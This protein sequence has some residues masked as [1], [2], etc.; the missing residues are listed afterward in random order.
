MFRLRVL[1]GFALE[2]PSGDTTPHLPQRRAEAVLAVLAVCGDLGCTRDRLIALLWPESD[3]AHARHSLRDALRAIRHVL[4]S[5]AI[6]S[7]GELLH[8]DPCVVGSDVLSFSLALSVDRHAHAVRAYSGALLEGFHVDGAPEFE[9]WLDGER[10]RLARQYAEALERLAKTAECDGEW[11]EAAGWW[12]RAVDHDPLNSHLVLHQVRALA[13]MGD[14][15]NAVQAADAHSRRLR[16]ELDLEPDREVLAKIERIRRGDLPTPPTPPRRRPPAPQ[17]SKP[18]EEAARH[19]EAPAASAA[20]P[21]ETAPERAVNQLPRWVRRT[22]V[23]AAAAI[24][25]LV[26]MQVFRRR[27]FTV[28]ASDMMQITSDPGV[29]FQPAI[30]PNGSEVAYVA[31][32]I[33]LPRPFVRSTAN[34][35]NGAAIR[36]DD[37]AMGSGWLPAWSPD[38]QLVR[39]LR[40]RAD[41]FSR[42][43][44]AETGKLGGLAR[45]VMRDTTIIAGMLESTVAWSPDGARVAFVVQDTIFT[46]SAGDTTRHPIAIHTAGHAEPHSLA[47]SPNG[48]YIA[49]VNSH[50]GWRIGLNRVAPASI[51]V[52]DASGGEPQ[53]VTDHDHLNVSPAWLDERHLLFVSNRD[54][55][56]ALYVVEVG[57]RGARGAPRLVPGVADPHSIS[58]SAASRRLAYSKFTV[59]QNIWAY[60]LDRSGPVSI[61]DGRPVTTGNQVVEWHDVSPDG[62]WIAYNGSRRGSGDLYRMPLAGGEAVPLTETPLQETQPRW[63][64]DGRE[65]VFYL[66]GPHHTVWVMPA[67]GGRPVEIAGDSFI[68]TRPR[69]SPDGRRIVFLSGD[70][71]WRAWVVSRDSIGGRWHR[72]ALLADITCWPLAWAPDGSGVLCESRPG[73]I[74]LLSARGRVLWRRQLA[75]SWFEDLR[76]SRD[77]KTLYFEG[78][79][80]RGRRGVWAIG[81]GGRGAVRLVVAFD[82]AAVA[83]TPWLSLGPDRLYLSV[84]EYESDIWVATL[85]Y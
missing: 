54:G 50:S 77:G 20:A 75:Y 51:W 27:P 4:G 23:L 60:P 76:Y 34:I 36:L 56:R 28:T 70:Q 32:P 61:R 83:A 37:A 67:V 47:W 12:A 38:G 48:R 71:S 42:C 7:G 74:F 13:A 1:G 55:T 31:G 9:R 46:A 17:P 45:P 57:P 33:G 41:W 39:Y 3:T 69:W 84:A 44:W 8:L 62:R 53:R 10:S 11:D 68:A 58:Y 19:K 6:R 21:A 25:A 24:V 35:A 43:G 16:Q 40:C 63:S 18:T 2:G 85:R 80:E 22:G 66:Q 52:V 26:A 81:D 65:I 78:T 49:Y 29:E 5:D 72:P 82:D 30:S 15:A 64:P 79:D 73:E 59:R 14:R